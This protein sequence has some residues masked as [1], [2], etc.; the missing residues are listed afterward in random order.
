MA[1]RKQGEWYGMLEWPCLLNKV[2]ICGGGDTSEEIS[3]KRQDTQRTVKD[4][5]DEF[6]PV[7]YDPNQYSRD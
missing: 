2:D 7:N 1:N 6:K 3:R 5:E 4:G